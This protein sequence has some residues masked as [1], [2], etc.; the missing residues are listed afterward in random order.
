[1]TESENH[2]RTLIDEMSLDEWEYVSSKLAQYNVDQS[3]GLSNKPGKHISL[4]LKC[5]DKIIG[6]IVGRTI[7][8]S[9]MIDHLW[10]D[11]QYRGLGYGTKLLFASEKVARERGCISSQTSSYSFQAPEFYQRRGYEVFG[12]FNGYPNDIKKFYLGKD[13]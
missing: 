10:V 3:E 2:D 8:M 5:D 1:M 6:G 4:S 7:Y 13:L 12:V 9:F 11:E